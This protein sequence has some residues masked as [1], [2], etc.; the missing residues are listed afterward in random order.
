MELC[1]S[2]WACITKQITRFKNMQIYQ[3]RFLLIHHRVE[4]NSVIA[5]WTAQTQ[6]MSDAQFRQELLKGTD[7]MLASSANQ[8]LL[9]G[10][11]FWFSIAPQTQEWI[12]EYIHPKLA[13]A[14]FK[15]FSHVNSPDIFA[16][17]SIEQTMAEGNAGELFETAYFDTQAE[18]QKWLALEADLV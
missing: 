12:H 14:G 6:D 3:S 17:L 15:R 4:N 5:I 2:Y 8:L 11:Q 18:A 9:D 16:Q 1:F 10:S 13:Q 7:A